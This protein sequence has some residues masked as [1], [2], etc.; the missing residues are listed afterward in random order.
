[1]GDYNNWQWGRSKKVHLLLAHEEFAHFMEGVVGSNNN[2]LGHHL[3]PKFRKFPDELL[4][5]A[6]YIT[7]AHAQIAQPQFSGNLKEE[8][9]AVSS[10]F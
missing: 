3:Q 10:A 4:E 2:K 6:G 8:V 9:A 7:V 5:L 1:V